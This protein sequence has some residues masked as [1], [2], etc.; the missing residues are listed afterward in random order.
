V[1]GASSAMSWNNNNNTLSVEN[2]V[3]TSIETNTLQAPSSL[4][5]TYTISSPTTITLD[6]VS[7]VQLDAP[8][9]LQNKTSAQLASF[10]ASAG[11]IVAVSDNSY[12]PAYY[13]G[14]VWKYVVDDTNV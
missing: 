3:A 9:K 7:E 2:I 6:P 11:S 10:V 13:N 14:S 12:K 1:L 8:M 4:V 5:G